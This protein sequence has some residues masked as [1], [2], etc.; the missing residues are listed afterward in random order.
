MLL[1]TILLQALRVPDS[2]G[3]QIDTARHI[4]KTIVTDVTTEQGLDRL[5]K[6]VSQLINW[7]VGLGL[8]II[9]A[10]VIFFIGRFVIKLLNRL[11]KRI[12]NAR[13][14]DASVKSFLESFINVI[15]QVML[16]VAVVNKLGIETTSFAA[17]LASFGV[18]VG[19]ALSGNLQNFA[20]GILI[21]LFRPYR[22][23]DY[24][25][26]QGEEGTV[27]AIQMLHTIIRTYQ[28]NQVYMPNSLMSSNK[29]T[30][31][32]K[33]PNRMVEWRIGIDYG[34]DVSRAQAALERVVAADHRILK[35]PAP[36]IAVRELGDNSV[37]L[38]VRVWAPTESY[39]RVLYDGNRAI[40]DEFNKQHINFPYPQMTIHHAD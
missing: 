6:L 2:V 1:A 5:S 17:L 3:N 16:L 28:G 30:N 18:A 24:V 8:R 36:Y 19:M 39:W 27:I 21:L 35:D 25:G 11:I 32:S 20:G 22:V 38:T 34:E 29:V 37:G 23:G 31:Y 14:V 33:E 26:A 40:Y 10:L 15:L 13:G 7:G 9:G 12:L 4:A